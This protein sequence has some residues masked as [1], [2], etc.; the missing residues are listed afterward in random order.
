MVGVAKNL[1]TSIHP[2]GDGRLENVEYRFKSLDYRGTITLTETTAIAK[3]R[4]HFLMIDEEVP[5]ETLSPYPVRYSHIPAIV[6]TGYVIGILLLIGGL[7]A[8][9]NFDNQLFG[10]VGLFFAGLGLVLTLVVLFCYGKENWVVFSSQLAGRNICFYKRG[11]DSDSF[12][13]FTAELKKRIEAAQE[14]S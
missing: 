3:W 7:W 5:F 11:P 12:D 6:R 14:T 10:F 1:T 8:L 9:A 4:Y 13:E 2:D